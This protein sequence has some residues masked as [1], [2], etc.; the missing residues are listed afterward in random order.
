MD[1]PAPL[2]VVM[3]SFNEAH[4]ISE[5]ILNLQGFAAEIFLVDSFSTDTTIDLALEG[6]V[7]VVQRAFR[8]FGD[9]WDYAATRLPITQ[10]WTMKL[11]PDERLSDELKAS[12]RAII[13]RTDV[14]AFTVSRRLWFMGRPLP[15]RQDIL[16]G[17]RTGHCRFQHVAVNEHPVVLGAIA[18]TV[19]ELVHLDSP[20]LHHWFAKQNAYTTAEANAASQRAPLAATPRLFGDALQRRMWFKALALNSPFLPFAFF[21]Y[22]LLIRGAWRAGRVGFEWSR[23]R[24]DVYRM[25]ALKRFEM[26]ILGRRY[27]PSGETRGQPDSRVG[28]AQD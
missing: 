15:V 2:A 28:Q 26:Q 7:H 25:I 13:Q 14:D 19:G 3:I 6:G 24:G 23:L 18:P 22:F 11:D 12:I 9:Q 5:V 1:A 20:H 27:E 10:P 21:C 16:R 8:G 4:N 17:W